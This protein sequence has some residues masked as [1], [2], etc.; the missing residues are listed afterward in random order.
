M[1]ITPV[2]HSTVAPQASQL[3]TANVSTA[4]L[5]AVNGDGDG[6]TG[7][8]ALNDGDAAAQSARRQAVDVKA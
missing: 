8:A 6:K 3:T 5:K 4:V 7:T 1:H 2:T